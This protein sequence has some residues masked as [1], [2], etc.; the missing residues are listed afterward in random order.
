MAASPSLGVVRSTGDFKVDGSF[1]QGNSTVFSG[2]TIETSAAQSTIR[3]DNLDLALSPGSRARVFA[4]H[5]VLETGAGL[6]TGSSSYRL[7]A[8][9]F[10]INSQVADAVWQ[11]A[12]AGPDRV[13]VAATKGAA[14]VRNANGVLLAVVRPGLSLAFAPQG[15][16]NPGV[17]LSGTVTTQNGNFYITDV[18]TKMK[19][20]LQGNNLSQY[21]GKQVQIQGSVVPG[22]TPAGGAT[23]VVQVTNINLYVPPTGGGGGGGGITPAQGA[24]IGIG[25]AGAGTLIG[26]A[27]SGQ[28]D[29]SGNVS[30]P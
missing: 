7:E 15:G 30:N 17:G 2:S 19:I 18:T 11:V 3:L 12:M 27:A 20:Q 25:L 13:N 26:L 9:K 24:V 16:A 23:E 8:A 28:F 6:V 14:E 22:T 29:G 10:R 21:V 5:A 1:V 4:D